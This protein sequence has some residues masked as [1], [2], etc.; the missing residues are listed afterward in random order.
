M[1]SVKKGKQ[2]SIA[3]AVYIIVKQLLNVALGDGFT[4]LILPIIMAVLL[5]LGI[6]YCNYGVACVLVVV[7]LT[8]IGTNL[9]NLGFNRYL[10][11]VI[12]GIIDILS[13]VALCVNSNIKAY[14]ET[15]S[16]T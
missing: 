5:V 14:F 7:A 11:Y 4:S 3:I 13:A 12:E 9:S 8:H 1:E 6:K 10:V 2:F 15:S 16:E